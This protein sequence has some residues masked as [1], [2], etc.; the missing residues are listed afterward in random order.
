MVFCREAFVCL[1]GQSHHRENPSEETA[2][3]RIIF[4]T[5][6]RLFLGA[7]KQLFVKRGLSPIGARKLP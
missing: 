1:Q 7:Q 4:S 3:L 2:L 5:T 6:F